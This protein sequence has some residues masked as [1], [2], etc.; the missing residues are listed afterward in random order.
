MVREWLVSWYDLRELL[1]GVEHA[2]T[3]LG[4]GP[5]EIF[6]ILIIMLV[7]VGPERLPGFARQAGKMIVSLRNWVQRSPD[8]MMLLRARDEL[9]VELRTIR[10][11]LTQEMQTVRDEMVNVRNEMIQ[12]TREATIDVN[13]HID[14]AT[15]EIDLATHNAIETIQETVDTTLTSAEPLHEPPALVDPLTM[16]ETP[17]EDL[18]LPTDDLNPE[19]ATDELLRT[20]APPEITAAANG[21]PLTVP[22]STKPY[23][24]I[25]ATNT[26][27]VAPEDG[28]Q[29][30]SDTPEQ[31]ALEPSRTEI[32]TL[33]QQIQDVTAEL[34]TLQAL[35]HQIQAGLPPTAAESRAADAPTRQP[36]EVHDVD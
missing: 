14:A 13:R 4:I 21:V 18:V 17:V 35:I 8:A 10:E 25:I 31:P 26:P 33:K 15:H 20:I 28:L 9:E 7:V 29:M 3:F 22:R 19:T 6:V 16:I 12:A 23:S 2:M 5:G 30:L 1:F 36:E 27:A 11:D 32:E 34:R 24:P